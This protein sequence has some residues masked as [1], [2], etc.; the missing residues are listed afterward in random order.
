MK[1]LIHNNINMYLGTNARENH[2]MIDN[3]DNN[4]W[5]FHLD[6][7]SSGHCI[8]TTDILTNDLILEAGF[9]VKNNSKYKNN[10]KIKVIYLQIK[11]IQKS[12]TPG[13]VILLKKPKFIYV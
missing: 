6:N 13:E 1:K 11:D 4:D 9:F 2:Q 8:V 10:N 3:A 7:Y 12:K 5:W